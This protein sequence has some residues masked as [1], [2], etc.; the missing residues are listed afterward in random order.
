MQG[1]LEMDIVDAQIHMGPGGIDEVLAAM[2]A[3]GI[4][5]VLVDEYRLSDFANKPHHQLPGGAQRPI[6][7]TAELASQLHPERFS[8][9]LRI[10]RLDP[11]H[12]SV[13]RHVRDAPGGRALRIDPGLSPDELRQFAE[14][15]HDHILQSACDV[16]L[17]LF[18]FAPDSPDAFV[19]AARAFPE[20]RIVVDHCGLYANSMRTGFAER[21]PLSGKEQL[22]LFDEVLALSEFPNVALKWGHASAMF[23]QG[24]WPGDGLWPILHRAISA[25]G[26]DRIMW[27]S[28]FSVNQSG[29]SWADLLYGVKGDPG[30]GE[31]ERAAVL[32]GA[33]R[34]WIDWPA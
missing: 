24:A 21:D 26:A 33:L 25:Y 7:P 34:A 14:G 13:V 4:R 2:D 27:A 1:A 18:V 29:E 28:D 22:A 19:R 3:L 5:A 8:W 11:D 32:G 12:E 16:G 30:L 31:D 15:G 20:L 9:L 6:G 17:P 10:S 23:D